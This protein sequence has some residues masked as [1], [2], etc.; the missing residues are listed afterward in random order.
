M[1]KERREMMRKRCIMILIGCLFIFPAL[2]QAQV[3]KLLEKV[4]EGVEK[5]IRPE[6]L[7]V[8]KLEIFPDPVREGQ[9]LAFRATISNSSRNTGRVTLTVRDSDQ[10]ISEVRN[11]TLRPGDNQI[12]FPESAYRFSRSDHCFTVEA[13]IERTH[14]P[15]DMA[16]EFCAKKTYSGWTLSDK[17]IGPLYVEDLEMYPDPV[18][19]GQEIRFKVRLRNDGRPIRG[20]IQVQD[21][22]QIVARVENAAIPRGLTEYQF[23]LGQYTF[24]RFDTCFTVSVDFEKTPYPV[25]ASKK[26]CAQPMGWT[27]R[28]GMRDHRGE[29]GK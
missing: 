20:H 15:I 23:P 25:D 3:D 21:R 14:R 7:K 26:Y 13:D 8:L 11:A 10:M 2:A 9:R 28:P 27:L 5:P 19:P 6:Y 17:G 22:D 1:I 4:I 18:S 16:M 12:D 29:R 24:Q